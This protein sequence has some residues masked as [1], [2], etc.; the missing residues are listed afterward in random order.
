MKTITLECDELDFDAIQ[1]AIARRQLFR[2]LPDGEGNMAG[3]I[4]AEICRGWEE[5]LDAAKGSSDGEE[6]KK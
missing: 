1:K 5:M 6:W 3:R 2:C 4:V